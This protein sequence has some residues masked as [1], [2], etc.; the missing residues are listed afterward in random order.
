MG[1]SMVN[2]KTFLGLAMYALPGCQ[3]VDIKLV[4][5]WNCGAKPLIQ[6]ILSDVI[7]QLDCV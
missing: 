7:L 5:G 2:L 4:F 6:L 1:G 3:K